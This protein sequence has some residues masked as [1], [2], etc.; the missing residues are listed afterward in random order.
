MVLT[1]QVATLIVLV[2]RRGVSP[3]VSFRL[4]PPGV[5]SLLVEDPSSPR[6][7]V[8][9]LVV[10]DVSVAGLHVM[11]CGA[12]PTPIPPPFA[13]GLGTGHG[14]VTSS[15]VVCITTF[16]VVSSSIKVSLAY[17]NSSCRT[18]E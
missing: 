16:N 14:G 13:T 7:V 10:V 5:I 11:G 4:C 3:V 12:S 9:W 17:A 6:T 15:L 8:N 2:D 1:F 18:L